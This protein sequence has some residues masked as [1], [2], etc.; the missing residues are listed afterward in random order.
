MTPDGGL[1]TGDI[2]RFDA[3]GF[4]YITGRIKEIYKLENGK[5][6]APAP[7]EESLQRSPLI[8]QVMVYGDNQDFN[9]AVVVPDMTALK[10]NAACRGVDF[11]ALDWNVQPRVVGLYETEVAAVSA[12]FRHFEQPHKVLV[13]AQEWTVANGLLTPTLKMKRRHLV[14]RYRAQIDQLYT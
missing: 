10:N 2:G 12:H 6:V 11:A 5:Y 7:L 3:D 14:E 9:I 13:S 8:S 1:R 4:L